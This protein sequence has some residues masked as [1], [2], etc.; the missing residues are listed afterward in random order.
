MTSLTKKLDI[1][2]VLKDA[3]P[4]KRV[5]DLTSTSPVALI[6]KIM[7]LPDDMIMYVK[8]TVANKDFFNLMNAS[9]TGGDKTGDLIQKTD[10]AFAICSGTNF[11][12][13]DSFPTVEEKE[14]F[15]KQVD[16]FLF[17][18]KSPC[19]KC[20]VDCRTV[21]QVI[22]EWCST[23]FCASCLQSANSVQCMSCNKPLSKKVVT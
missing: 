19:F 13:E 21:P 23:V 3:Y 4:N 16:L 2:K 9:H 1:F 14:K 20:S 6:T 7:N 10:T 8:K 12:Y 15:L 22:C 5:V 17:A 11:L 18:K